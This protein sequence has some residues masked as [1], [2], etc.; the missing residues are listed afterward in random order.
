MMIGDPGPRIALISPGIV[1]GKNVDGVRARDMPHAPD[2]GCAAGELGA[3]RRVRISEFFSPHFP[4][5]DNRARDTILLL[6]MNLN[7]KPPS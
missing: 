6:E 5:D 2:R 7:T 3:G 4:S 1:S